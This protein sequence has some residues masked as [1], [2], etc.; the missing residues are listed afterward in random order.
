MKRSI[1]NKIWI[2]VVV[3]V[4]LGVVALYIYDVVWVKT[5]FT[6]NLL[7]TVAIVFLLLFTLVK[8]IN[9]SRR[10]DL[11]IYEKAYED[12]IGCA[13]NNKPLTRKKL[14]CA[15]RLYDEG[16]YRKALKCLFQ[17][18]K[19]A[20]LDRDKTT[21]LLFIALC[22]TDVGVRTEAI[23][24]Y[25]ALLKL[26]P[27]NARAHSNLSI[28]LS[29]DGDYDMAIKHCNKSIEIS[30]ENYYAY[31]NRADCYFKKGEYD[32]AISD[33]KKALEYKNNGV[34][35][36]TL[37]T[38]IYAMQDDEE[39]KK[40]YYHIAITAGRPPQVLNQAIEYFLNENNTSLEDEETEE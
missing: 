15:C 28:V 6:R 1:G 35:A 17:L 4:I 13:F 37:L 8:L 10:K 27:N 38:I 31:A 3:L 9:G 5:P 29:A 12:V 16:N 7:R 32:N 21:V 23:K 30:P 34:E 14:L 2:A 36:A 25:Y 19:E 26:D 20:D 18:L 22:Y 40:H 33:A 11:S 24:A 39:N